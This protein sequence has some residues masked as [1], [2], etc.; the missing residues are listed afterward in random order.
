[1]GRDAAGRPRASRARRGVHGYY[2]LPFLLGDRL[3]A[4]VDLRT[5]RA[6]GVLRVHAEHWEPGA[7]TTTAQAELYEELAQ[8]AR[9]VGVE[10]VE[11]VP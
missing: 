2:V 1:M 5:A 3:V 10:A 4:R 7:R 8:L 9:F 11:R 6:D